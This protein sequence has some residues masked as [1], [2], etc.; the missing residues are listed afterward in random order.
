MQLLGQE[1]IYEI[2]ELSMI[3]NIDPK[4]SALYHC[5]VCSKCALSPSKPYLNG[6]EILDQWLSP[7]YSHCINTYKGYIINHIVNYFEVLN[8]T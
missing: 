2:C 8:N 7:I 5:E 3:Y 4:G 1:R 6:K